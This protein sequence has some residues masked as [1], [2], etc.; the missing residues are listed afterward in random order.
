M[1]NSHV[2]TKLNSAVTV[3]NGNFIKQ[4]IVFSL[5][6]KD[7]F[8]LMFD[9]DIFI[10]DPDIFIIL[11]L[12]RPIA[13]SKLRFWNLCILIILGKKTID[14]DYIFIEYAELSTL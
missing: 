11:T 10:I 5:A 4:I 8:F 2:S 1:Y 3:L 13:V 7:E 6:D 9:P 14:C 12:V